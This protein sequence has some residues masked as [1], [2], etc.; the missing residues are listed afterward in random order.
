[1]TALQGELDTLDTW[2]DETRSRLDQRAR[3]LSTAYDVM[4]KSASRASAELQADQQRDMAELTAEYDRQL[5]LMDEAEREL[6]RK[7]TASELASIFGQAGKTTADLDRIQ[8]LRSQQAAEER[9]EAKRLLQEE[10]DTALEGLRVQQEGE[11]K[12]LEAQVEGQRKALEL[13]Q[14][15]LERQYE[16]ARK[17]YEDQQRA[18]EEA[19]Q[20]QIEITRQ[21]Y[22]AQMQAILQAVNALTGAVDFLTSQDVAPVSAQGVEDVPGEG[23]GGSGSAKGGTRYMVTGS[24]GAHMY[25]YLATSEAPGAGYEWD[26][27]L[28]EGGGGSR[29]AWKQVNY[30]SHAASEA[31]AAYGLGGWEMVSPAHGIADPY[32]PGLGGTYFREL[33]PEEIAARK[34][35]Q[36]EYMASPAYAEHQRLAAQYLAYIRERSTYDDGG[37]LMP[38]VTLAVNN[39]GLP[40]RVVPPGGFQDSLDV[41]FHIT[42]DG[43]ITDAQAERLADV[44]ERKLTLR[45]GRN[46]RNQMFIRGR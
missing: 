13:Q 45:Q 19:G 39:T 36:A 8:A 15:S 42:T 21:S 27:F 1:E 5:A 16:A 38:G 9:A 44:L 17:A 20:A 6:G 2:Y 32:D 11:E 30:L 22:A 25:D 24:G 41:R 37:W 14:A 10:R 12:R 33:T 43:P 7:A 4:R 34:Q 29:G 46:A 40:E 18:I 35:Y 3:T 31:D 28:Y 23:V 26:P